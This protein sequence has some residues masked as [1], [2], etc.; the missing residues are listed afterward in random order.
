MMLSLFTDPTVQTVAIGTA[1]IGGLTGFIGT[2]AVV[3]KQSLYGDAVSHAALPGV[4]IAFLL[5]AR[6][7]VLLILGGAVAGW[8]GL[9][10]VNALARSR[11]VTLDAALGGML[12]VFFG[13]GLMLLSLIRKHVRGAAEHGLERYLFG[14]AATLREVDLV[15][16]GV[17]LLLTLLLVS[18]LWRPLHV[19]AFDP[20][21]A[22]VQG[23]PVATLDALLTALIV[24]AVVVGLQAVGVVLMS[25]LLVAPAVA[26]RAWSNRLGPMALIAGVMGAG[27]GIA[28]TLLSHTLSGDGVT[29]PTGP[30]IVLSATV[31]MG[32]SLI[33]GRR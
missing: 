1:M 28:G 19:L 10:I 33:G 5:G 12:A 15:P 6:E 2:F 20:E 27:A 7:P 9:L 17:V 22:A 3:R 31:L 25:S 18:L 24:L 30:T 8:L 14:Q 21:L 4:A 16:I 13:V 11:R 23:W 29:V 32:V 26:A